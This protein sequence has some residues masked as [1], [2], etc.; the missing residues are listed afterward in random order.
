MAL[1]TTALSVALL[2]LLVR[3]LWQRTGGNPL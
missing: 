2:A 1:V 3:F